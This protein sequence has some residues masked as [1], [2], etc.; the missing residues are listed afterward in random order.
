M[1]RKV[2][3]ALPVLLALS[4]SG[5]KGARDSEGARKGERERERERK[6]QPKTNK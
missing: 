4:E 3:E 5:Q 2:G 6:C 1:S